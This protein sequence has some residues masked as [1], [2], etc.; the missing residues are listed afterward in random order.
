MGQHTTAVKVSLSLCIPPGHYKPSEQ[1]REKFRFIITLDA[2]V[3]QAISSRL[4]QAKPRN[5][6][7]RRTSPINRSNP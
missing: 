2:K 3:F 4:I 7:S 1:G 6:V 5:C